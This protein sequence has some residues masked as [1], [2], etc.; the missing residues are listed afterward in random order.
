M[1]NLGRTSLLVT[2]AWIS[3]AQGIAGAQPAAAAATASGAATSAPGAAPSDEA[4]LR[5]RIEVLAAELRALEHALANSAR[6]PASAAKAADGSTTDVR[7]AGSG[8]ATAA[9]TNEAIAEELHQLDQKIRIMERKLELEQEKQAEAAKSAPVTGAGR[10]GFQI[11]SADGAYQLRFRGLL[12][13]DSRAYLD[14]TDA[15][16]ADTFVLRRVRPIFD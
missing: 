1:T 7:P 15:Q 14:D 12:H 3:L 5:A 4:S 6:V 2:A 11:R 13:A 16:G 10:D 9:P 8:S